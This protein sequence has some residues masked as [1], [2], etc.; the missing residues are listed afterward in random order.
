MFWVNKIVTIRKD[1]FGLYFFSHQNEKVRRMGKSAFQKGDVA[2]VFQ[3][4]NDPNIFKVTTLLGCEEAYE[5]WS[6]TD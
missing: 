5:L 1:D 2:M 6:L 4:Q 3:S